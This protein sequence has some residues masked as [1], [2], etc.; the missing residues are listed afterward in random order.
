MDGVGW[1]AAAL[2]CSGRHLVPAAGQVQ[3]DHPVQQQVWGNVGVGRTV[4]GRWEGQQR[5]CFIPNGTQY[6]LQGKTRLT[7]Q[8]SN[9]CAKM[10]GDGVGRYC[11]ATS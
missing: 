3:T 9:R 8:Y 1:S 7:T 11:V 4:C 5:R 6:Q 2:L 10:C